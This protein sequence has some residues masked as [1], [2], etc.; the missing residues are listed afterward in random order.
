M[1]K[2][3]SSPAKGDDSGVLAHL[4]G[5]ACPYCESGTLEEGVYKDNRAVICTDCETPHAQ[6]W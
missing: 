2:S 1:A 6:L 4:D 5:R 3:Q